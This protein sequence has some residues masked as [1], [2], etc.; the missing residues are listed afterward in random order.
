MKIAE[1]K[2][3]NLIEKMEILN[4]AVEFVNTQEFKD[5]YVIAVGH[6]HQP[7][8]LTE[9][10]NENEAIGVLEKVKTLF[11]YVESEE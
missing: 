5:L 8:L 10:A 9:H 6:D 4:G 11:L 1:F 3:S 2:P 7:L